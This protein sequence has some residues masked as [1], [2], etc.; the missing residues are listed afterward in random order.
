MKL[1]LACLLAWAPMAAA[2]DSAAGGRI[3]LQPFLGGGL[4]TITSDVVGPDSPEGS[5]Q[6]TTLTPAFRIGLDAG[7][8]VL[9]ADAWTVS[10][11]IR[12][13]SERSAETEAVVH[14]HRDVIPATESSPA[15]VVLTDH[16]VRHRADRLDVGG[17][18]T[19]AATSFPVRMSA[20][21]TTSIRQQGTVTEVYR[22]LSRTPLVEQRIDHDEALNEA[23]STRFVTARTGVLFSV[24]LPVTI[25]SIVLVPMIDADIQVSASIEDDI[26]YRHHLFSASVG[27]QWKL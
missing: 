6:R 11:R 2:Q 24:E 17:L 18:I 25:G 16:G 13:A 26:P 4:A 7:Y 5:H 15:I 1:L 12:L 3:F 21:V 27:L 19:V 10:L 20:G 9:R 14:T 23:L 8:D 22:E